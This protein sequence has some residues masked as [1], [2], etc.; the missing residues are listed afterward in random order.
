MERRNRFTRFVMG[1]VFFLSLSVVV[2]SAMAGDWAELNKMDPSALSAK[3]VELKRQL[4]QTPDDYETMKGLGIAYH[5]LARQDAKKYTQEAVDLLSKVYE[6]NPK[7]YITLCYLGSSTTMLAKTTIN[8]LKKGSYANKGIG[9]MDKAIRKDPDNISVR[10]AR[11]YNS[12]SLPSF[13][14]R[15]NIAVEDFEYLAK[16][17]E[18]S[19][20]AYGDLKKEVY[21]NLTRLYEKNGKPSEARKYAQLLEAK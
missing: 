5:L 2:A 20:E 10:L 13:M 14:K 21:G 19:P 15:G 8:P 1:S 18:A 6:M 17:I 16:M 9:L 3:I 12:M 4:K 7:D 11:A